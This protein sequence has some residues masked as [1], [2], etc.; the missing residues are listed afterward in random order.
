MGGRVASRRVEETVGSSA[1]FVAK[2]GRTKFE[3]D[4]GSAARV[5]LPHWR[6]ERTPARPKPTAQ[7]RAQERDGRTS[8]AV[9]ASPCT[10]PPAAIKDH[11][12]TGLG[13]RH[14][15]SHDRAT[16]SSGSRSS[17]GKSPRT[18]DSRSSTRTGRR[19]ATLTPGTYEQLTDPA[20]APLIGP[21]HQSEP[22][23]KRDRSLPFCKAWTSPGAGSAWAVRTGT[24]E[25]PWPQCC[26][27]RAHDRCRGMPKARRCRRVFRKLIPKVT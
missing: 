16:A 17:L 11:P 14:S 19:L 26:D 1:C 3:G 22:P 21:F 13:K 25:K 10:G 8:E 23:A 6:P 12:L 4:V 7:L 18:C 20:S 15:L 24:E 27:H 9:T 2:H 5:P